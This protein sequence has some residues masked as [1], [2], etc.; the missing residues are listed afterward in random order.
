MCIV[1]MS[2][3]SISFQP[4][5]YF[6]RTELEDVPYVIILPQPTKPSGYYKHIALISPDVSTSIWHM[7]YF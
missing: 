4:T 6:Q 1:F 3:F 7:L 2:F 5:P